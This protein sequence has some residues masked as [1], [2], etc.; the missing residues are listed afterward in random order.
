MLNSSKRL[1]IT[2]SFSVRL[3]SLKL[4]TAQMEVMTVKLELTDIER[5]YLLDLLEAKRAAMIHEL[6]HTDTNDFKKMLKQKVELVE[7]LKAKIE[8]D[9]SQRKSYV[10]TT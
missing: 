5:E 3:K 1:G 7:S 9:N 4:K 6:H 2:I 8:M 10:G